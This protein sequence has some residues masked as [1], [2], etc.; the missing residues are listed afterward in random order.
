MGHE[1]GLVATYLASEHGIGVRAGKF[2]A[3]P[4]IDR[5]NAG[6]SALRASVGIGTVT[7]DVDRLVDGLKSY[8]DSAPL[9]GYSLVDGSFAPDEDDRWAPS[10]KWTCA[11]RCASCALASSVK[12]YFKKVLS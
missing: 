1:P 8:L 4:L 6:R 12:S 11:T 3:H 10:R 9:K 7:E 2:C 5:I